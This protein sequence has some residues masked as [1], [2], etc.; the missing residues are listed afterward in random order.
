MSA[1]VKQE[2][3]KA[4][5]ST[6]LARLRVRVRLIT[7][8]GEHIRAYEL[9]DH[10][11]AGLPPFEPGSH[12]DV[13]L[14][15]DEGGVRQY[16]LCGDS[17]DRSRY[18]FAVQREP[19]GRGGS[20]AIFEHLRVDSEVLISPPRNNFALRPE[21]KRHLLLA[22]GIGI[23][24]MMSMVRHLQRSGAD[25]MLHY[26]A[27]SPERTAFQD[28]LQPLVSKGLAAIHWDDGDPSKGLDLA[29]TL[30]RCEPD[31][32]V[33]YCGPPG[34]MEAAAAASSHWPAAATHREFFTP[35]AN[36]QEMS[37]QTSEP[38]LSDDGLG[39]AFQ[40]RIASTGETVDIPKDQTILQVL[41][42][43]G[44]SVEANCELGV[45]GTCRT[46][47]LEGE[48]DHRDFVLEETDHARELTVCCSRS[49]SPLLVLDL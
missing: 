9:V 43:H 10:A 31:T 7:R 4:M 35:P 5:Q 22:G 48:P 49:R 46:R 19:T 21:A 32:H 38:D 41:R 14:P 15:G 30:E 39:A 45:C 18:V 44:I 12:I 28:E 20:K 42:T 1:L 47:F 33:Y 34:F 17:Q 2:D 27:R 8:Y 37:G 26:C 25:F 29:R 36:E 23:T 3:S 40:V 13:C 11:G 16:S 24:P 6:E